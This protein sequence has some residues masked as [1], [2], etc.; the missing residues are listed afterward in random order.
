[1]YSFTCAIEQNAKKFVRPLD[2]LRLPWQPIATVR[3]HLFLH[4]RL[5]REQDF[6]ALRQD[7]R[8]FV[9]FSLYITGNMADFRYP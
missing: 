6:G 7:L 1:M 4:Q 2:C 3:Q 9:F 5:E 8:T